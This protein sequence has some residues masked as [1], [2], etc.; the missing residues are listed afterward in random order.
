MGPF[1]FEERG[2]RK[3]DFRHLMDVVRFACPQHLPWFSGEAAG[4]VPEVGKVLRVVA[5]G[6]GPI[7]E[8]FGPEFEALFKN[9]T[10]QAV[11]VR[12]LERLLEELGVRW[13]HPIENEN[14]TA[15]GGQE[16]R[17]DAQRSVLALTSPL[18]ALP[19]QLD[20]RHRRYGK[21]QVVSTSITSFQQ[22]LLAMTL[23]HF[24]KIH[25]MPLPK[26]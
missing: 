10:V 22:R 6:V 15:Q 12:H 2:R 26:A 18:A 17:R 5:V 11:D 19:T 14:N 20:Q 21:R 13:T 24:G 9:N 7:T 3:A 4:E 1:A 8:A 23:H 16:E 25:P